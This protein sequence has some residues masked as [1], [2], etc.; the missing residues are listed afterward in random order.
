MLTTV[1]FK[2]IGCIS[3]CVVYIPNVFVVSMTFFVSA[4]I[5]NMVISCSEECEAY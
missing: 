1:S 5:N 3:C 2:L 4:F